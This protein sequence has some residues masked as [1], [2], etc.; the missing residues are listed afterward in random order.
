MPKK[1]E[2]G[3]SSRKKKSKRV[4]IKTR[5]VKEHR[6]K[7]KKLKRDLRDL[8]RDYRSLTGRRKRVTT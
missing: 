3:S 8:E 4:S 6:E 5:L 7:I 2:S 1:S